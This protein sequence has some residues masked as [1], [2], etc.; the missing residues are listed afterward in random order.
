MKNFLQEKHPS[1]HFFKK[2][3][4]KLNPRL[5]GRFL[6]PIAGCCHRKKVLLPQEKKFVRLIVRSKQAVEIRRSRRSRI[7]SALRLLRQNCLF[8]STC[9]HTIHCFAN[10]YMSKL[11]PD[12]ICQP[13]VVNTLISLWYYDVLR[14]LCTY[15]MRKAYFTFN[16]IFTDTIAMQSLSSFLIV[17]HILYFGND[18]FFS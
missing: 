5:I 16:F 18:E 10:H 1:I 15:L 13:L 6:S 7:G 11:T 2:F 12:I 3:H 9:M 4:N 8:P 14:I 17:T